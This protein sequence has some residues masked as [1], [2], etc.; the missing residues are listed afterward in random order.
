MRKNYILGLL[1]KKIIIIICSSVFDSV[2]SISRFVF[3]DLEMFLWKLV[4]FFECMNFCLFFVFFI[5]RLILG[6]WLM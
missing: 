6:L 1:K 5:V 2:C 3:F 4:F